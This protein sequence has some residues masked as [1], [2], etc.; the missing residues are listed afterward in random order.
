[1]QSLEGNLVP[2]ASTPLDLVKEQ[3]L[4]RAITLGP[5]DSLEGFSHFVGQRTIEAIQNNSS[6]TCSVFEI[7]IMDGVASTVWAEAVACLLGIPCLPPQSLP[8]AEAAFDGQMLQRKLASMFRYVFSFSNLNASREP[9]LKR[10]ARRAN[11]ELRQVITQRCEAKKL[12]SARPVPPR[13]CKDEPLA[14]LTK[15]GDKL[16][17][18][19]FDSGRSVEEVVSLVILLALQIVIPAI[20][21]V[22]YPDLPRPPFLSNFWSRW[23]DISRLSA[24]STGSCQSGMWNIGPRYSSFRAARR[25]GARKPCE[26]TS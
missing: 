9:A 15:H 20:F 18:R 22:G 19:L 13:D 1:M 24:S 23:T 10:D 16:L 12:S 4:I 2:P 17:Q 6:R 11:E 5:T 3:S 14:V 25:L 21:A 26:Y 8:N 7:D